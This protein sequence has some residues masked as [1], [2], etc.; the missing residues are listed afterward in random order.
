VADYYHVEANGAWGAWNVNNPMWSSRSED[1]WH[2]ATFDFLC[3]G[4]RLHWWMDNANF[5]TVTNG[6][7]LPPGDPAR[8]YQIWFGN[9]IEAGGVNGWTAF[10]VDWVH[11]YAVERPQMTAPTPGGGGTQA[12]SWNAVP[13]TQQPDGTTWGVEYEAR[14]CSDPNCANVA[15][16]GPWTPATNH[17]FNGLALN[18]TYYYQARAKWVGTPALV[19]CWGNT[20]A[21]PMAGEPALSLS[22]SASSPVEPGGVVQYTLVVQNTGNGPDAGVVVRDP[23]PQYITTP[24][25]ISAGGS[26][27]GTD[28][29]WSLGTLN[30][31]ESRTLGW[32]GRVDPALPGN[33][34]QIVNIATASD[35]AGNSD[36]AQATTTVVRPGITIAKTATAQA[37]PGERIDYQI[38]VHNSG[39]TG[40]SGVVVR[41]PIPQ[42]L[43]NPTNISNGGSV[44]GSEIVWNLGSLNIGQSRTLSWRGTV[45]PG[46]PATVTQIDNGVTVTDGAG[47]SAGAQASTTLTRPRLTVRKLAPDK[48]APG[49]T[50][51]Y[52]ITVENSG[53]VAL[54]QVTVRDPIPQY[55]LN[56]TNISHDG[57]LQGNEVVWTITSLAVGESQPLSWQGT[58][59]PAIPTIETETVNIA[60]ACDIG[61][62]CDSDSAVTGLYP[63]DA[64]FSKDATPYGWPGSDLAYTLIVHNTSQVMLTNIIVRDPLP[65]GIFYPRQISHGGQAVPSPF[66]GKIEM[67]W[68]VEAVG[69]G[70]TVILSW[71][72]TVDPDLPDSEIA[73]RNVAYLSS[74][75]GLYREAEGSSY[76]LHQGVRLE[77]QATVSAG[78][79]EAIQYTLIVENPNFAQ[80]FEV[81]VRDQI[82]AYI[83]NPTNIS[84]GGLGQAEEIIWEV[85]RM[86]PGE[87]IV[88]TWEGTVDPLI[89]A[90]ESAIANTAIAQ[91]VTGH[92]ATTQATTLLK[93]QALNLVK[94]ASYTVSPGSSIDYAI[95]VEN[96]G[97]LPCMG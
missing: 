90:G 34:S 3:D 50:I 51:D 75:E 20:V 37:S 10:D 70:E 25:N 97:G 2:T 58:V 64:D 83:L 1:I 91:D 5:H 73:V 44:Q 81:V 39:Q 18:Q 52:Q 48:V 46:A 41:D 19:T 61:N 93:T 68:R 33:V 29:V 95:T 69:P 38:T 7:L 36:T 16:T 43:T 42:Y 57:S 54:S 28:V 86:E 12:I 49:N 71:L 27:Q 40:L 30:A 47:N 26:V 35:D 60:A 17:T 6:P 31:G 72:G 9:L 63:A 21:A 32:Q 45:E 82:P 80:L 87:Q 94:N 23:I 67:V 55:I 22:K 84:G 74:D 24:S 76:I 62:R 96:T 79:G 65:D 92:T 88:L 89:P 56:P 59:D 53:D 8:P 11:I 85:G 77:K 15:Q 14:A 13:N 4:Q 78:P 66:E